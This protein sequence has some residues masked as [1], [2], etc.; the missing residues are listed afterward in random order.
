MLRHEVSHAAIDRAIP[1]TE[2]LR[3]AFAGFI[4]WCIRDSGDPGTSWREGYRMTFLPPVI[5]EGSSGWGTPEASILLAPSVNRSHFH[6]GCCGVLR[7]ICG[8]TSNFE[9]VVRESVKK[10]STR[11]MAPDGS[12]T[13][14]RLH[15][16]VCDMDSVVP[17]FANRFCSSSLNA[18]FISGDQTVWLPHSVWGGVLFR[19]RFSQNSNFRKDGASDYVYGELQKAPPVEFKLLFSHVPNKVADVTIYGHADLEPNSVL[20]AYQSLPANK[21]SAPHTLPIGTI[22]TVQ[23]GNGKEVTTLEWNDIAQRLS[24]SP[25]HW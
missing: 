17:G 18:P 7:E 12:V 25:E 23:L 13:V 9:I 19:T 22:I 16:W 5:I 2:N 3:E 15:E 10:M 20:K 24:K 8:S 14:P 11:P 6:A 21:G 1:A 4:E